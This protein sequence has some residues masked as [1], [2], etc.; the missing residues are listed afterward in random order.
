MR[1]EPVFVI[2]SNEELDWEKWKDD[3]V[4]CGPVPEDKRYQMMSELNDQYLGDERMNLDVFVGEPILLI[5]DLGLW[6]GRHTGYREIQS[7]NLRDCLCS[8]L[9]GVTWFV[10]REGEFRMEGYHHDGRNHYLYRK[11]RPGISVEEREAFLE[12][13]LDH[14]INRDDL[15]RITCRLGDDI[16]RIYGFHLPENTKEERRREYER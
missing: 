7:G 13:I 10:D 12:K 6:D 4:D 11:F 9:D 8:E 14:T 1:E 16:A 2:W 15:E 5:A 3:F